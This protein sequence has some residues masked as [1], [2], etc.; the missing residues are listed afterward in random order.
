MRSVFRS[1]RC[2][3]LPASLFLAFV[4]GC[5]SVTPTF[6]A[7]GKVVVQG[8]EPLAGATVRFTSVTDPS[9][10]LTGETDP[11]GTFSLSTIK[12]NKK[13]SGAMPGEYRVTIY[14]AAREDHRVVQPVTIPRPEKVEARDNSYIFTVPRPRVLGKGLSR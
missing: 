7:G 12:G 3:A 6:F 14:P 10:S 13:M 2:L 1:S 4:V 11:A 5:G 9:V 8:G